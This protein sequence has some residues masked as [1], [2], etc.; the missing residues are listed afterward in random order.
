MSVA[1]TLLVVAA[2][3]EVANGWLH[4][5]RLETERDHSVP[6]VALVGVNVHELQCPRQSAQRLLK[7]PVGHM[8]VL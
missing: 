3:D 7:I 1:R 6:E 4:A 8:W 5:Q 2:Q